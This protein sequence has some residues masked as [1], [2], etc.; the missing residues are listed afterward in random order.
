MT[1]Q[2]KKGNILGSKLHAIVI[3][4]NTMGIAGA[5]L[6]RQWAI[7]YP[8]EQSIYSTIGKEK[9][10]KVGEILP[11]ISSV[12]GHT[13]LCFPTKILPQKRSEL[14][15]I[16][17]GLSALKRLVPLLRIQSVA[18]PALGCGL[19]GLSWRQVKP[20]IGKFLG[21]LNIVVHVYPPRKLSE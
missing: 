8:V 21:E 5:G 1:I 4:V 20:L 7:K 15:W 19:G 3:P 14:V 6:A 18:V 16:E 2:Y 11:V 17:D 9:R 10:L 13:F 12:D